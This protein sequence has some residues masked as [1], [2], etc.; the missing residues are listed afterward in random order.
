MNKIL[1]KILW[2]LAI[3]LNHSLTPHTVKFI[4]DPSPLYE[5]WLNP[6]VCSQAAKEFQTHRAYTVHSLPLTHKQKR[7]SN[8][9]VQILLRCSLPNAQMPHLVRGSEREEKEM[10]KGDADWLRGVSFP[11]HCLVNQLTCS[12]RSLCERTLAVGQ[13]DPRACLSPGGKWC[14]W[15]AAS[16]RMHR[17]TGRLPAGPL[18]F[19]LSL[20]LSFSFSLE[21]A[22]PHFTEGKITWLAPSQ[23]TCLPQ[24]HLFI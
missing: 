3:L 12:Q 1:P 6:A 9:Q 4:R 14:P 20:L 8:Q 2:I 24:H 21:N 7:L 22:Q 16:S 18:S 23:R 19:F 5:P 11:L 10:K 15:Y 17:Q 13:S